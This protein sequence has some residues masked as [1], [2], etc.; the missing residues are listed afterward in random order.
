MK[1]IKNALCSLVIALGIAAQV[2]ATPID[3][4]F[5]GNATGSLGGQ[6]FSNAAFSVTSLADTDNVHH[7]YKPEVDYVF[8]SHTSIS[9]FGFGLADF[10][11]PITNLVNR[12]NGLFIIA[13]PVQNRL[14]MSVANPEA[15]TYD[16][17]TSIGPVAGSSLL[18]PIVF[19]GTSLG[20]L[21]FTG[22]FDV[23]YQA[24]LSPA[25][26]V[27]EPGI[28]MLL[29]TGLGLIGFFARRRK[30]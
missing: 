25:N 16:L 20:G 1:L 4:S 21:N 8:A 28:W 5:W 9:I 18:N 30:V 17:T 19:F 10:T 15:F 11:I 24:V 2:N 12:N 14:I 22:I 7:N 6:S 13:D 3:F 26:D 23:H 27:P 29:L